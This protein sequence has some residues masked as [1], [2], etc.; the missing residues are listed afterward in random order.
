MQTALWARRYRTRAN[1]S[2]TSM[3]ATCGEN[4]LLTYNMEL[5]QDMDAIYHLNST[6][7]AEPRVRNPK[8][9]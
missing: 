9:C 3:K 8:N 2:V 1:K 7:N 4:P 5:R 6:V